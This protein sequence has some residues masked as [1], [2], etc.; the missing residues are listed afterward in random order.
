MKP[1]IEVLNKFTTEQL[2]N[3]LNEFFTLGIYVDFFNDV[4][5][6]KEIPD[7]ETFFRAFAVEHIRDEVS[8]EELVDAGWCFDDEMDEEQT[9]TTMDKKIFLFDK[10]VY[11]LAFVETLTEKDCEE[12]VAK[13]SCKWV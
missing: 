12:L 1:S 13:D 6:Q 3:I 2:E 9:I 10:D 8:F 7:T 4:L 5:V 11:T